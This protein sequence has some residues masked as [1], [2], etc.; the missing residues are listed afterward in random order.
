[1]RGW[2]EK[3]REKSIRWVLQPID[4][5]ATHIAP[6]HSPTHPAFH[7]GTVSDQIWQLYAQ[8]TFE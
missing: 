3:A 2:V 4:I 7:L 6:T 1:M 8:V 5:P